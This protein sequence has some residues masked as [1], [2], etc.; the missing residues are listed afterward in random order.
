VL[1]EK[2]RP[3]DRH[4]CGDGIELVPESPSASASC[5]ESESHTSP[6]SSGRLQRGS[7]VLPSDPHP[8]QLTRHLPSFRGPL[9]TLEISNSP[10]NVW[11][12]SRVNFGGEEGSESDPEADLLTSRGGGRSFFAAARFSR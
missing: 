11:V 8:S 12:L 7:H 5:S 2:V 10:S 4:S 1:G 3:G 6:T 9:R